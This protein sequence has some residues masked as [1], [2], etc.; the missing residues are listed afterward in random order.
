MSFLPVPLASLWAGTQEEGLQSLAGTAQSQD[1]AHL[2]EYL[3]LPVSKY[4]WLFPDNVK[5]GVALT[6]AQQ[7]D[8]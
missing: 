3:M 2:A 6:A 7:G 5:S 8:R 4:L 1:W